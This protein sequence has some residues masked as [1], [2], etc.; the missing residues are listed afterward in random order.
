MAVTHTL[1]ETVTV[2]SG[3]AAN[4]EF[5]SIPQ[6]YTDIVLKLS[7]RMSYNTSAHYAELYLTVNNNAGSIYSNRRLVANSATTY[8]FSDSSATSNT[9]FVAGSSA[10]ASVFGNSEY[11][12]SNYASSNA[13][14]VSADI[15]V[16]TNDGT[17]YLTVLSAVLINTTSAITSL[18]LAATSGQTLVQFS[19][20]S[21]Y[22]IKNS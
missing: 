9:A 14:S 18:K 4:I 10:T 7:A 12:F 6:T 22:G 17:N 1:I 8:S 15:A 11:Y 13:K 2:G 19:S 3:G 16:E 5:T 20:A 21:L